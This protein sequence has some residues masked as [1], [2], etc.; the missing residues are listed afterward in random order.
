MARQRWGIGTAFTLIELLVVISIIALL[1]ALLLPALGNAKT[2]ALITK[3]VSQKRQLTL[4][5]VAYENDHGRFAG[6]G[7]AGKAAGDWVVVTGSFEDA[8]RRAALHD[9][10]L[11]DYLLEEAAYHSPADPRPGTWRS[12]SL[13]H[14]LGARVGWGW[15]EQDPTPT[16]MD[17][18]TKPSGTMAFLE[19][20]DP[21]SQENQ[22]SWV[23]A[24]SPSATAA[25]SSRSGGRGGAGGG[26]TGPRPGD[27]VDWPGNLGLNGNAHSFAD[28]HAVFHKFINAATGKISNFYTPNAGMLDDAAYFSNIFDPTV[29]VSAR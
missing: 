10:V 16:N 14:F 20:Y 15:S 22:G 25:R 12:D 3:S 8:Q 6:P 5:W 21:R 11:W 2:S 1:I 4:G 23:M 13:N 9:G 28:G 18:L 27:W 7:T 26:P 17:Q 19:E 24:R 29:P